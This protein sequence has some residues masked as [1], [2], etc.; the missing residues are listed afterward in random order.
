MQDIETT[1]RTYF[2]KSMRNQILNEL[3]IGDMTLT[4][5][6]RKHGIHP[7]TIHKWKRDMTKELKQDTIDVQEILRDLEK[8]KA[9]NA[10]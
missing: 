7:V 9:E 1:K 2:T 3:K 10:H 8:L 6:A 5:L 4:N